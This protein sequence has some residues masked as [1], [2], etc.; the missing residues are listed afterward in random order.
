MSKGVLKRLNHS[1]KKQELALSQ[2]EPAGFELDLENVSSGETISIP[3]YNHEAI[4][5]ILGNHR[6]LDKTALELQEEEY[7]PGL[8]DFIDAP[9]SSLEGL[10]LKSP[11]YYES[12]SAIHLFNN[13]GKAIPYLRYLLI[14]GLTQKGHVMVDQTDFEKKL[15]FEEGMDFT[16]KEY[17][18]M[19]NF[20]FNLSVPFCNQLGIEP[21][22]ENQIRNGHL[23]GKTI[24]PRKWYHYFKFYEGLHKDFAP[25]TEGYEITYP[26]SDGIP[27]IKIMD[28][29]KAHSY[30][31]YTHKRRN[32]R[33]RL[34]KAAKRIIQARK[35][36]RPFEPKE[37]IEANYSGVDITPELR[38]LFDHFDGL[39]SQNIELRVKRKTPLTKEQIERKKSS[40]RKIPKRNIHV[41]VNEFPKYEGYKQFREFPLCCA[42]MAA[43]SVFSYATLN[44]FLDFFRNNSLADYW[45]GDLCG[46]VM[47][48]DGVNN[49]YTKT[50]NHSIE[51]WAHMAGEKIP[52]FQEGRKQLLLK[53]IPEVREAVMLGKYDEEFKLPPGTFSGFYERLKRLGRALP[54]EYWEYASLSYKT[55]HMM[56]FDIMLKPKPGEEIKQALK[57]NMPQYQRQAQ[58]QVERLEEKK[59]QY[60]SRLFS[61]SHIHKALLMEVIIDPHYVTHHIHPEAH[62]IPEVISNTRVMI[63][64]KMAL[65]ACNVPLELFKKQELESV[66]RELNMEGIM[67][68]V[69]YNNF[70]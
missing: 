35:S 28:G 7:V 61:N 18:D 63:L 38:I 40:F 20:L 59:K 3:L 55:T 42:Y 58:Q 16:S 53:R 25:F 2:A 22:S 65:T 50:L 69:P 33:R 27:N 64:T 29:S 8:R 62:K 70:I 9:L 17:H 24:F 45:V 37:I 43:Q 44:L 23:Q 11:P 39:A 56:T 48:S 19:S 68:I 60:Q 5:V 14:H 6:G 47:Y 36:G 54:T 15:F 57:R 32:L 26:S 1:K 34:R 4:S 46:A 51:K 52:P 13:Q 66:F 21:V 67:P 10:L 31:I 41:L 49:P 30:I 12:K